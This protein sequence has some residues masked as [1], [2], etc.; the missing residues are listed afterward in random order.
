MALQVGFEASPKVGRSWKG[1]KM[2]LCG[3]VGTWD[4]AV[5]SFPMGDVDRVIYGQ[6]RSQ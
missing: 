3:Q 5:D 6:G 1:P 2:R 4:E